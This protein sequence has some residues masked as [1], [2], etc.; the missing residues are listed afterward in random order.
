[1]AA[2]LALLLAGCAGR[3]RAGWSF[4]TATEAGAP[5]PVAVWGSPETLAD[6]GF[7]C[8]AGGDML[9][10]LGSEAPISGGRPVRFTAAGAVADLPETFVE[11]A[12]GSSEFLIAAGSSL[13]A[14]LA[15]GAPRLHWRF[16]D[17]RRGSVA[18][19]PEVRQLF[20][21]CAAQSPG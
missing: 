14:A 21:A 12:V 1:M 9:F 13:A 3:E 11:D 8:R 15:D 19:G 7:A 4:K 16:A 2:P 5:G 10:W 6:L 20:S 17:G 18:L